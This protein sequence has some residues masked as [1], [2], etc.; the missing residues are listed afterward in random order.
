MKCGGYSDAPPFGFATYADQA[1]FEQRGKLGMRLTDINGNEFELVQVHTACVNDKLA[2]NEVLH[3]VGEHVVTNDVSES[4]SGDE[5]AYA[6]IYAGTEDC[7]ESTSTKTYLCWMQV[8]GRRYVKTNGDDDIAAGDQIIASGD[9]TCDSYLVAAGT[10]GAPSNGE[11]QAL[12]VNVSSRF[13][14]IATAADVDA[15]DIVMVQMNRK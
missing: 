15:S 11:L 8:S 6:G 1:N 2:E 9:G 13:I 7:P 10:P 14:G 5:D 4:F 3:Y 12:Q